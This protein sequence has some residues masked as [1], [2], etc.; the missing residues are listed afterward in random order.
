MLSGKLPI[1][2]AVTFDL[3]Q[4]IQVQKNMTD[5]S[6]LSKKVRR[7]DKDKTMCASPVQGAECCTT[8]S[9]SSLSDYVVCILLVIDAAHA[10]TDDELRQD[11]I[12]NRQRIAAR[13][14][15]RNKTDEQTHSTPSF[16]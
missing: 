15:K 16:L 11:I 14:N 12:V 13:L 9:C 6:V 3:I 1:A 4:A 5:Y 10:R 7:I 2:S 8:E